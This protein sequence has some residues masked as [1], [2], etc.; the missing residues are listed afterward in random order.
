MAKNRV[1]AP[2]IHI[3]A[4]NLLEL[5][6]DFDW[7]PLDGT[8]T[9]AVVGST[10]IDILGGYY[11]VPK[12]VEMLTVG[13]RRRRAKCKLRII[14][15]LDSPMKVATCWREMRSLSDQ[16]ESAGYKDISVKVLTGYPH[17]HTKLFHFVRTTQHRWFVGS[18]NPGSA[19]HE[20]MVAM[21]GKHAALNR[22]VEI[23]AEKATEITRAAPTLGR[24]G[25]LRDFF[26]SGML[27]HT[28][29]RHGAFVFDAF[30][31]GSDDREK[32]TKAI[33]VAVDVP[34]ANPRTQGFSFNLR[35]A[36]DAAQQPDDGEEEARLH[37]RALSIDTVLGAWAPLLY[38]EEI[39][40]RIKSAEE[41]RRQDLMQ[42]GMR[43]T[44]DGEVTVR[45]AYSDYLASME[46]FL[47][48]LRIDVAPIASREQQFERFLV[49]RQRLLI[50]PQSCSRLARRLELTPMPDIWGEGRSISNFEISFF[51]DL[52]FRTSQGRRDRV[53]RSL[54]DVLELDGGYFTPSDLE[55][56][57]SSCLERYLWD[58]SS[59]QG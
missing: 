22:Y 37:V 15:G 11:S 27:L 39:A 56:R 53:I 8:L 14:V 10:K 49:S 23:V 4:P 28:P 48:D 18:A 50:D 52:A 46:R 58:E 40:A 42:L 57:L 6:D 32:I 45:R 7:A 5:S 20:L 31:L 41:R 21:R 2:T 9:E 36:A 47:G 29:P 25:T 59:W 44:G 43:I 17:F 1:I 55:A 35:S 51:E 38:A 30:R 16:L 54:A 19:R 12:M 33:S 24:P 13:P 34:H 26:L 3:G